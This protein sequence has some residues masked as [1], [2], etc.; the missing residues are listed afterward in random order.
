[1]W[2]IVIKF[3]WLKWNKNVNTITGFICC[4]SLEMQ[5]LDFFDLK[6]NSKLHHLHHIST[7]MWTF[8][9]P[10]FWLFIRF[11]SWSVFTLVSEISGVFFF[12]F[13]QNLLFSIRFLSMCKVLLLL[14]FNNIMIINQD[15]NHSSCSVKFT[16]YQKS[17]FNIRSTF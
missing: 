2:M 13:Y 1:M 3:V 9:P 5:L 7:K 14:L 4:L 12:F 6:F 16:Y 8:F 10:E 15:N 17:T 11:F